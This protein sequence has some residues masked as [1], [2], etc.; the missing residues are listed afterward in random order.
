V[1]FEALALDYDGTIATDGHFDPA[2]RLA[3]ARVRRR[4]VAVALVTGRRLSDLR[5]VAGDLAC[6]DVVVA[7]NGAVLEFPASRR[8]VLLARP[9]SEPFVAA[10]RGKG[11]DVAVGEGLVECAASAAPAVLDAIRE[12]ELP[13][14]LAFNRGRMMI[15]P[16]AVAKSTGLRQ[17]L[18]AL[19][20][21]VHNTVAIGDAE[22]DHDLLD[23]CE[24]GVAVGWGSTA[25]RSVADEVIDGAGPEAIAGYIDRLAQQPRLTAR[26][27]GRRQ[28]L[29]GHE[30]SGTP[31]T[32]AIRGR[33]VLI[34][35]EPGTGKSW[36]AGALC[37]QLILQRYSLCIIDPEGDYRS[38]QAL[39]NVIVLGGDDPP[40]HAREL[41]RAIQPNVSVLIDLS[42]L[43]H[44]QKL[45]YLQIVLPLLVQLRRDTGLPHKIVLDEAHYFLRG[46][47]VT[48]LVDPDL[49]GYIFVT[50]RVSRIDPAV[51]ST[52]D[53][54]VIVTRETDPAESAALV[55][56]C[57]PCTGISSTVFRDLKMN[58]A[59]LLPGPDE[60][61]G[62]LRL[63]RTAPRMTAHVRHQSKYLDMPVADW[64]G[65]VFSENGRPGP[66]ARTLKEFI[67]LLAALPELG[68]AQ[69]MGRHDFSR[70]MADVFRDRPLAM[71]IA[72]LEDRLDGEN[73]RN[74]A[75]DIAQAIRAR[76]DTSAGSH[77]A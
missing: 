26:Q 10:V 20:L 22:N 50:Y 8:H 3:I 32:L 61:E 33:T 62:R 28:L 9:P 4:G 14:T 17:A 43:S 12:L 41:T 21:S 73:A 59:V 57:R 15:L 64:L 74:L 48:A 52:R 11:I 6:F 71:R 5:R 31:V 13:L 34:A 36:V 56:L 65:F 53:A 60:S 37:E 58:E 16:P 63:F 75:D 66:R 68:L 39:P 45:E 25:L 69:H 1:K 54:V 46:P 27:M 2:V 24:V 51:R 49:E 72:G 47:D 70:W 29:L 55:A 7:E 38:L 44:H 18:F 67:G 35:G 76:Y 77:A 23:V 40:P 42:R 19:R 30:L